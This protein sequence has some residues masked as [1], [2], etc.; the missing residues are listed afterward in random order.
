MESVLPD[1]TGQMPA[2]AP[3]VDELFELCRKL[4]AADGATR[5]VL[6]SR[7]ALS[8]PFAD[9]GSHV[10]LGALSRDDAVELVGGV[11]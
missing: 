5:I 2:A 1:R 7:E 9:A 11:M 3:A 4:L 8:A 6:T 10:R